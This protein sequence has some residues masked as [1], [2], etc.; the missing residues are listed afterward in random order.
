MY[1]LQFAPSECMQQLLD[2]SIQK[3]DLI[4]VQYVNQQVRSRCIPRNDNGLSSLDMLGNGSP[5]YAL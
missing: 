4:D 1:A 5:G 2:Y 3:R